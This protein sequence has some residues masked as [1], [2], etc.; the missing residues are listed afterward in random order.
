MKQKLFTLLQRAEIF[1]EICYNSPVIAFDEA[2]KQ[3][4]PGDLVV[5]FG[6]FYT[7]GPVMAARCNLVKQK[8][9]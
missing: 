9:F 5:V 3:A 4:D 1:A 7:V 8:E 6:S 2:I